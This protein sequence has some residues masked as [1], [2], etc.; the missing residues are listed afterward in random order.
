MDGDT[1][2]KA[3]E[4]GAS[5]ATKDT[6]FTSGIYEDAKADVTGRGGLVGSKEPGTKTMD[7]NQG[8]SVFDAKGAVGG[9]FTKD[10]AVGGMA[11][12]V[13]GPLSA[14]GAIGKNFT[15]GGSIGGM[16]QD[17]LGGEKK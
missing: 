16:V 2:N 10:G 8:P 12:K 7:T 17:K 1:S 4:R 15:Q 14:D 9:A 6:E 3:L 5:A 13:G 11:E